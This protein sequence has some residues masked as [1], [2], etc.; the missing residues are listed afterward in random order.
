MT[1][2]L[3]YHRI[4]F[5]FA[6]FDFRW[7]G[8]FYISNF[9]PCRKNKNNWMKLSDAQVIGAKPDLS[10]DFVSLHWCL[11]I[12]LSFS[13]TIFIA[14]WCFS[15][16]SWIWLKKN[17]KLILESVFVFNKL[18]FTDFTVVYFQ[19]HFLISFFRQKCFKY[20]HTLNLKHKRWS[21]SCDVDE[22]DVI[23]ARRQCL[24]SMKHGH[25]LSA[26]WTLNTLPN[27][28]HLLCLCDSSDIDIRAKS[29]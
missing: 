10:N 24:L 23:I 11:S 18:M 27:S 25:N 29:V 20:V 4:C 17:T 19:A 21:C 22:C 28:I 5:I 15:D 3:L 9:K 2:F 26:S 1:Q 8:S 12:F 13:L 14:L 6:S 16:C 7:S